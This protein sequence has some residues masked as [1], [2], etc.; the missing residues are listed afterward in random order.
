M[1][2]AEK[3]SLKSFLKECHDLLKLE[4]SSNKNPLQMDHCT[5]S[6]ELIGDYVGCIHDLEKR[7]KFIE[8][9]E[10]KH[11]AKNPAFTINTYGNINS[12]SNFSDSA[13]DSSEYSSDGSGMRL[14][15]GVQKMITSSGTQSIQPSRNFSSSS[16][17]YGGSIPGR[18]LSESSGSQ[19][20]TYSQSGSDVPR[21]D[22][23][24]T[25]TTEALPIY[26]TP[27]ILKDLDVFNIGMQVARGME[28][29]ERMGVSQGMP[30]I[31]SVLSLLS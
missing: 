24:E 15:R 25:V 30:D 6:Q 20:R 23:R 9:Y 14:S 1:E 21:I 18:T 10:D 4:L 11:S 31:S 13:F 22:Q 12:G 16:S 17:G 27:G 28:H 2:F 19:S 5:V 3:G 8:R 7:L 29:L 26:T